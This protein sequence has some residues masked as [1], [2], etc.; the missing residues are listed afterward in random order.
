[1]TGIIKTYDLTANNK[2]L[3]VITHIY[4]NVSKQ[5]KQPVKI[6]GNFDG[7]DNKLACED[8]NIDNCFIKEAVV[9]G[10]VVNK[11]GK[12]VQVL[13]WGDFDYKTLNNMFYNASG[14]YEIPNDQLPNVNYAMYT[15]AGC[16]QL[17]ELKNEFALPNRFIKCNGN[18]CFCWASRKCNTKF[19][20]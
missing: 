2:P 13:S 19:T 12:L 1:V 10:N 3:Q 20:N 7:I 14:L 9:N 15:F 18:V 11:I 17:T 8:P 16:T 4:D 6:S 5:F